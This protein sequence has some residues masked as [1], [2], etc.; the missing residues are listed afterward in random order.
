MKKVIVS[1]V[2]LGFLTLSAIV[3]IRVNDSEMRMDELFKANVDALTQIEQPDVND[4]ISDPNY[5]CEA[6]HPTDPS[7]DI[8]RPNA[9]W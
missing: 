8:F 9:R 1:V 5:H 2:C 6:L 4:C 3:F 7:K